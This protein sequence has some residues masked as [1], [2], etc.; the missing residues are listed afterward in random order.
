MNHLRVVI[1]SLCIFLG[2]SLCSFT[3]GCKDAAPPSA[4]NGV[5]AA[6]TPAYAADN[7]TGQRRSRRGSADTQAAPGT[8][9]FYLLNLSWSPEFCATH[10]GS[11][12]CGHGLGFVV[13]GL[14]PQDTSGDY[15]EDCSDAR[16]PTNP[17][18]Y[19]DIIPTV[20][21]IAH[22]WQ[23]AWHLLRPFRRCLLRRHPEGVPGGQDP[24]RHRHSGQH[25]SRPVPGQL[26]V[27]Q[28]RLSRGKHRAELRQQPTDGG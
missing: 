22:E 17:Q 24:I 8:F 13:H 16:G 7:R 27:R 5:K 9:D 28:P 21:L 6:A 26:S 19:T 10:A 3:M 12:E 1:T 4:A 25:H 14:W 11:P 15:P 20:S 2:M 23:D 18:S